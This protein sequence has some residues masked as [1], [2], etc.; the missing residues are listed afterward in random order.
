MSNTGSQSRYIF[1]QSQN[2]YEVDGKQPD[3]LLKHAI[4]KV[5]DVVVLDPKEFITSHSGA[6]FDLARIMANFKLHCP[7]YDEELKEGI[8]SKA[9]YLHQE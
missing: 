9:C 8:G 5:Y 1:A 4:E 3:S 7:D 6:D 2:T